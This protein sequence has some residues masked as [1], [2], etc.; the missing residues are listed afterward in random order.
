MGGADYRPS[1]N[2]MI[3]PAIQESEVVTLTR[4]LECGQWRGDELTQIRHAISERKYQLLSGI[5]H[6]TAEIWTRKL[7]MEVDPLLRVRWDFK[8]GFVIDRWVEDWGQWHIVGVLGRSH[9]RPDLCDYLKSRDMQR[10]GANEYLKNKRAQ[11]E[12]VCAQNERESTDKVLAAV[13]S[14]SQK[15]VENFVQVERARHTG[16]T[17]IH[18]GADLRFME[19]VEQIQKTTPAPPED[20]GPACGNPGMHPK[21]YKRKTGGKHIRE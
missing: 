21:V 10:I 17:I 1:V 20:M 9:I 8:S 2:P 14:L 12:K 6:P 3:G 7:R 13:D 19:H 15:Q 5:L 11:A 16:E 4:M 18:H